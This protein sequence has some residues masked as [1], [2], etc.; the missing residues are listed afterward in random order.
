MPY[1]SPLD[2]READGSPPSGAAIASLRPLG[3][4]GA[5]GITREV[6]ALCSARARAVRGGAERRL[7]GPSVGSTVCRWRFQP[8]AAR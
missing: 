2:R 7:R 5:P 6:S 1:Q 4:P 8:R 3:S